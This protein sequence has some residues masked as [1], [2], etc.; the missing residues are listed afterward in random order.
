MSTS[1][2]LFQDV[3]KDKDGY[4]EVEERAFHNVIDRDEL[5]FYGY[6]QVKVNGKLFR[7]CIIN[8][9]VIQY[10]LNEEVYR[11]LRLGQDVSSR[12]WGYCIKDRYYLRR[13]VCRDHPDE[14]KDIKLEAKKRKLR[15]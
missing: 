2:I 1:I 12:A 3:H 5:F 7:P 8:S 15:L 9:D 6:T 13:S 14:F 10:N 11:D 4:I